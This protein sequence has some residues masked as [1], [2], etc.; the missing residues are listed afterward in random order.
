[1]RKY[2]FIL[3]HFIPIVTEQSLKGITKEKWF[4]FWKEYELFGSKAGKNEDLY[5]AYML[6]SLWL[7]ISLLNL[8]YKK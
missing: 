1:M 3:S 8:Y 6:L 2:S 5:I 4:L 7:T